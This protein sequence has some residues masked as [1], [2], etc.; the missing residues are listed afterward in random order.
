MD[1]KQDKK[2]YIGLSGGV[3]SAYSAYLLSQESRFKLKAIFMKNWSTS[4]AGNN[5][6]WEQDLRSA[7][8]ASYDLGIPL[9]VLDLEQDYQKQVLGYM[10][11]NYALGLTPNP[12]IICNQEIKFKLFSNYC[13]DQGADMIATGHWAKIVHLNNKYLLARADNREK[14]QSYF[15][16]R[17]NQDVLSKVIFPLATITS[18]QDMRLL[19]KKAGLSNYNRADSQGLCF[20]G[21]IN[22]PT[23]LAEYLSPKNGD[24]IDQDGNVVGSHHGAYYYTIGQ[25]AGLGIGGGQGPYYVHSIDVDNNI[26]YVIDKN[27]KSRLQKD[28]FSIKD[29]MIFDQD[30]FNHASHVVL[31]YQSKPIEYSLNGDNVIL[32]TSTRAITPGQFACF[33]YQDILVASAII[34]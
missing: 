31:R 18:K 29:L 21:N 13:F 6:P 20:V 17:I 9:E 30:L 2:I 15:L 8:N 27:H 3:D 25:R 28:N 4:S 1:L 32:S 16:S 7:T 24:I 34:I 14:D 11:E 19:A 22:L 33:Y 12:D 23:F 10:I 26:V 5:C